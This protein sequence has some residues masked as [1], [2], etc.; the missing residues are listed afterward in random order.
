MISGAQYF[1]ICWCTPYVHDFDAFISPDKASK[2]VIYR[3]FMRLNFNKGVRYAHIKIPARTFHSLASFANKNWCK[4]ATFLQLLSACLNINIVCV[5]LMELWL[6]DSRFASYCF[7][8]F[9][10]YFLLKYQMHSRSESM[11]P[12]I[13]KM[14]SIK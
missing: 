11:I 5:T 4:L 8:V 2:G 13:R 6:D 7:N 1:Y 9:L 3:T 10:N 14:M 12:G